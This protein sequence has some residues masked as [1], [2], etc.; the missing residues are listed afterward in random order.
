MSKL[1]KKILRNLL[2]CQTEAVKGL[3]RLIGPNFD[4]A[5]DL[6]SHSK[7]KIVV[8]GTGKSGHVATKIAATMTSLGVP[9]VFVHPGEALHGD[10]G[11]IG[12]GDALIA[13]SYSGTTK[14][15]LAMLKHVMRHKVPV[16]GITGHA[17]S[18]LAKLSNVVLAFSIKEEG[19]PFN[20]APMASTTAT[21]VIGDMLAA[22][23][24][25]KR[26]FTQRDFADV[27]PAGSL[28]LQ[29][30]S[31]EDIMARGK[32]IPLIREDKPFKQALQEATK[33]KLGIVGVL[34]AS[35]RLI[36]VLSD[37]DI[38]RFLINP[39]FSLTAP[40]RTAMTRR[41]KTITPER[42]LKDI[43]ALMEEYKI[44]SV[45]VT[46]KKG[47]PVGIVHMHDIVEREL[48]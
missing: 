19:S 43:V 11:M 34:D 18:P 2:R 21:G 47:K 44:T 6:L 41:P 7:G 25:V 32:N 9:A 23:L 39:A 45:F 37:G 29:L 20:L 42:S 30:T 4:K 8:A 5:I 3:D 16:I 27:H 28:G 40:V 10:L 35:S 13:I 12:E 1:D 22:A 15:L 36:G 46:D 24:S 31:A 38:R 48:I 33:K 17:S 26:G 14:E